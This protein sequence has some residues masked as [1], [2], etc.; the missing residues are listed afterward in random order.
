MARIRD[1]L[2]DEDKP[3]GVGTFLLDDGSEYYLDDPGRARSFLEEVD[4]ES[5]NIAE[6]GSVDRKG[7]EL[8]GRQKYENA[9]AKLAGAPEPNEPFRGIETGPSLLRRAVAGPGGGEETMSRQPDPDELVSREPTESREPA[10]PPLTAADAEAAQRQAKT[11]ALVS[12]T[13]RGTDPR[14]LGSGVRVEQ[15]FS[16]K[17]GL[18]VDEYNQQAQDRANAYTA[19]NQTIARHYRED[20]A[21]AL[22]QAAELEASAIEQRKANDQQKL[23][24]QR[25]EQK[26]TE[27]RQWLEK[28]VD[29]FYDK[30]KPDPDRLFKQ[31]GVFGN[32]GAA[33]AQFMGAYAAVISNS[34]NFANQI[35]DKKMERDIDSQMEDFRRGKMKRDGQLARM[36]ERGMSVEQMKSALRLQQEL[37][38]QK[39][40]KAA[41]LREGTREAK[42]AAEALLMGR[43]E[44][45]VNEENK[46]RTAALGEETV[47]G[48]MVRPTGPRAKSVAEILKEAGDIEAAKN[49]FNLESR[50]GEQAVKERWR[51]EDR[52]DKHAETKGK[53][54]D[55]QAKAEAAWDTLEA[56]GDAAGVKKDPKTGERIADQGLFSK[57][58]LI[59]P[60]QRER[61]NDLTG[62]GKPI[63]TA[64]KA[65]IEGLGRLQSGGV[66]GEEEEENFRKLLGDEGATRA[67]IATNLNALRRLILKRRSAT[68]QQKPT[69]APSYWKGEDEE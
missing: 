19:T 42:Q 66:I 1:Y 12:R 9:V 37:V 40:V 69:G 23:M 52:A 20:E 24:L 63:E 11:L 38:V 62:Q 31:R 60:G 59:A 13:T 47:S 32:L 17:G 27:D 16:R 14:S 30:S 54:T 51:Q 35:L 7:E 4:R 56:F 44:P 21:A 43:Q 45:F 2:Q 22:Q 15:N 6:R 36:A 33:I 10:G 18:P 57:D 67:Q 3:F 61:L 53:V 26:Y 49:R 65:A 64:R 50:G 48:Q 55:D 39:E 68:N 34:P 41:A 8:D 58:T 28:D 29:S 5:T 46:F 25:K